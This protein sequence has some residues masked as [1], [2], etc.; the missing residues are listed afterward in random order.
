MFFVV[1]DV[2]IRRICMSDGRTAQWLAIYFRRVMQL[3]M[4]SLVY[5]IY[6]TRMVAFKKYEA[7]VNI[8]LIWEPPG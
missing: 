6:C 7:V 8:F 4:Q 1:L 3:S 2:Q 5:V